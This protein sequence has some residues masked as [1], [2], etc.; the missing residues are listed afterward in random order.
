MHGMESFKTRCE[1]TWQTSVWI[2]SIYTALQFKLLI[3]SRKL[4]ITHLINGTI[5]K[6]SLFRSQNFDIHRIKRRN[7]KSVT[8]IKT[9]SIH[10]GCQRLPYWKTYFRQ[11]ANYKIGDHVNRSVYPILRNFSGMEL[12]EGGWYLFRR[13]DFILRGFYEWKLKVNCHLQKMLWIKC[14]NNYYFIQRHVLNRLII[15]NW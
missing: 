10:F 2:S 9:F 1:F 5:Y 4:R 3:W 15:M 6:V 13:Q 8:A 12:S 11:T 14:Q 7:M